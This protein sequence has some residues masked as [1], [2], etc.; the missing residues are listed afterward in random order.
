MRLSKE[1][2]I[3]LP[4]VTATRSTADANRPNRVLVIGAHCAPDSME[5]HVMDSLHAMGVAARFETTSFAPASL[6]GVLRRPVTKLMS[7]TLR[8]PERRR[9]P[10]IVAAV[11]EYVPSLVLVILGNG[12][13][14][15]TVRA[16]R[17]ISDA[18]IL[19]WC[20][21]QMTTLGR[22]YLLGSGYDAVFVKDR[23]LQDLFSRMIKSSS[24]HYLPE[25]CNPRIHSPVELT[26]DDRRRHGCDIM[27][28]GT[29]YYYRQ[30]ILQQLDEFDVH[31]WGSVPDWIVQRLRWPHSGREIVN[32]EKAVAAQAATIA[33]N[34]LHYAEVDGINCRA[35]ELAGCGAFQLITHKAA[36]EELFETDKEVVSF[37]TVDELVEKARHFVR[38][39]DLA[40]EIGA[41]A[42]VRA[43]R[44]HTYEQ[45]LA[46]I[47]RVAGFT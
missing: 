26:P 21:D 6:P 25:A 1:L 40:R 29:L 12:L 2:A 32:R 22:Q 23:Y 37:S 27:V 43:H 42:A 7:L 18:P 28:A 16:I 15:K 24:F 38:N 4:D 14:P 11:R 20:Q 41:R 47:F 5:S 30:A 31:V 10:A 36:L 35:F 39:P 34:P 3:S 13:S 33:L 19:C 9:E 8:E 45:R 46:Q 44:D 17:T